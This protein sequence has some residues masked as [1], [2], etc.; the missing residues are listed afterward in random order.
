VDLPRPTTNACGAP[1]IAYA[2]TPTSA[3]RFATV[4]QEDI[5]PRFEIHGAIYEGQ[6]P[7]T[8]IATIATGCGADGIETGIGIDQVPAVGHRFTVALSNVACFPLLIAGP[9]AAAPV[10]LCGGVS[11]CQQGILTIVTSLFA[12]SLRIDLPCE[13]L[14]V[15]DRIAFQGADLGAGGGCSSALFGVPFRT[16]DR[17]AVTIR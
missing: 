1:A 12:P 7:E 15:G 11:P 17:L 5:G 9:L 16:T 6:Q 3:V 13:P 8:T 4:W 2:P 10:T 14:L